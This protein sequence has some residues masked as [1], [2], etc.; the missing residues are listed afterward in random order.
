MSFN[1][2]LSGLTASNTELNTISNNIANVSTT[3]FKGSR[4]EFASVYSGGQAGGVEVASISQNFD[5]IGSITDTGRSLDMAI[6]GGGFFITKDNT[7]QAI[8]TRSGVFNTDA[9]GTIISNTGAA[10]QGYTVD[11]NN[12]LQTGIIGDLVVNTEG[13]PA[14]ATTG[15]EFAANLDATAEII[16]PNMVVDPNEPLDPTDPAYPSLP[17]VDANAFNIEDSNTFTNS[18]TTLVYD[19]LGNSHTV[20]QYFVKTGENT[21]DVHTVTNGSVS[22]ATT[23]T[24][25]FNSDG[26]LVDDGSNNYSITFQ[27]PGAEEMNIQINLDGTTQYGNNFVVSKNNPDGYTSGEFNNVVVADDGSVYAMYTN[28]QSALQGQVVL[29][30]FAAPQGLTQ[31]GGTGWTQSFSSGEALIGTAGTGS[32]GTIAAGALEG[33]NVDLTQSLVSLMT[34]QR[35]YQA[36]TKT[37]ST[38]NDL[39]QAL[40]NAV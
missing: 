31:V 7:G 11:A 1:I 12:N 24:V 30:N 28:G 32:L 16:S 19:S 33:S 36:N 26:S 17:L 2:A 23:S 38:A 3:G 21:W 35:N 39:T 18:Y 37:I 13:L 25:N 27:P 29:A 9:S 10:L 8:Y 20:A 4:T 40:F 15:I 22:N 14:K 6:A 34:A 5:S